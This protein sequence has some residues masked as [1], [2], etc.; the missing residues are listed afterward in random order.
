M[1]VAAIVLAAGASRRLRQ[2]KQLLRLGSE[3]LL[4]HTT[5]L[6]NEAGAAPVRAVLGANCDAILAAVSLANATAIRNE[7]WQTG[8][9]S[10]IH[11]G[12][13]AI[14]RAATDCDGAM[15]LVCDQPKLT[16][17]HLRVLM[18]E[19]AL[20]GNAAIVASSYAGALGVPTI[21]PRSTFDDLR[22]LKGDQGAR[23]LLRN[24]PC[25]VVEIEFAG[26][27][28]DIDRPEDLAQL[29]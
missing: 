18:H 9:A 14:A 20:S 10:S 21:F 19:F 5:R 12:L 13:D 23:V 16:A 29:G 8:I 25:A 28:V 22:R 3:T 4:E 24:P 15:V 6:A 7:Q 27:E 1:S 26:G 2:P 17:E 11:A